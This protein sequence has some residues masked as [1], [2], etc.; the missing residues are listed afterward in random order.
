MD[1]QNGYKYKAF[2]SYR[3]DESVGSN[4]IA[5]KLQSLLESFR[6]PDKSH[7]KICLDRE[8]FEANHDLTEAIQQKLE[9][10]EYLIV[11]LSP[12]YPQSKWCNGEI[13][14]FKNTLHNG[15]TEN[16]I[17]FILAG[18]INDVTPDELKSSKEK[19]EA[20]DP[21]SI[22]ISGDTQKESIKLL[23][24]EYLRAVAAMLH[25]DYRIISGY[26]R[27]R[28]MKKI[29]VLLSAATLIL[30]A[31]LITVTSFLVRLYHKNREI[32]LEQSEGLCRESQLLWS[33]GKTYEALD[34]ALRSVKMKDEGCYDIGVNNVLAEETGA[35]KTDVLDLKGRIVR[36]HPITYSAYVNNGND[37]FLLDRSGF[38]FWNSATGEAERVYT[39]DELGV[40][41]YYGCSVRYCS[42]DQIVLVG[43]SVEGKSLLF[44]LDCKTKEIMWKNEERAESLVISS[45]K[46][47]F[48]CMGGIAETIRIIDAESGQTLDEVLLSDLL[49]NDQSDYRFPKLI[50][51]DS[52][53]NEFGLFNGLVSNG[54][55][56]FHSKESGVLSRVE[57]DLPHGYT[58]CY[59]NETEAG[60]D[61]QK[62]MMF[63]VGTSDS[64]KSYCIDSK[65]KEEWWKKE[66]TSNRSASVFCGILNTDTPMYYC[67]AGNHLTIYDIENGEAL[68]SKDFSGD[69]TGCINEDQALLIYVNGT[70]LHL[71]VSSDASFHFV[72]SFETSPGTGYAAISGTR[73][74][75]TSE[76]ELYLFEQEKNP[77]FTPFEYHDD[78][79]TSFAT[80]NPYGKGYFLS[81]YP[82]TFYCSGSD[83]V[84]LNPDGESVIAE[85][86]SENTFVVFCGEKKEL[87]LYDAGSVSVIAKQTIEMDSPLTISATNGYITVYGLNERQ[88]YTAELDRIPLEGCQS[89]IEDS[90][91][92]Q[93]IDDSII[94]VLK[95]GAFSLNRVQD[96]EELRKESFDDYGG[97]KPVLFFY[98]NEPDMLLIICSD[99]T[100]LYCKGYLNKALSDRETV[101][102]TTIVAGINANK[103]AERSIKARYISDENAIIF[104]SGGGTTESIGY[105]VDAQ[106]MEQLFLIHN[107]K[108]Y[109]AEYGFYVYYYS[110]SVEDNILIEGKSLYHGFFPFY[111]TDQLIKKAGASI[112]YE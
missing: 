65:T 110:N 13:D 32:Q 73:L 26:E 7:W 35:F 33:S 47:S 77:D 87:L 94:G 49:P 82:D 52:E 76:N 17:T 97:I 86:V 6:L 80:M 19:E 92:Y 10:S 101:F 96:G 16:I 48:A 56:S 75:V 109:S 39:C 28:K 5:S 45:D 58:S 22:V 69:I 12:T 67:T 36:Q 78:S 25:T 112:E 100:V 98:F 11:L 111:T 70:V 24:K 59:L 90:L 29:A 85:F 63:T 102:E 91:M 66:T 84:L 83:E 60:K 1:N 14:Y 50:S 57:L 88:V 9:Q 61:Y 20:I 31:F 74:A 8:D 18:D 42:D 103:Y 72:D 43:D 106:S 95:D 38:G 55:L 71:D 41:D 23:K 15:S 34:A 79:Y 104:T 99:D 46:K 3:H 54:F 62:R 108:G 93:V 27:K 37:L 105:V 68:F 81:I 44:S 53:N 4:K 21:Y 89:V 107:Y 2:I 64:V 40:S 30:T 51:Y